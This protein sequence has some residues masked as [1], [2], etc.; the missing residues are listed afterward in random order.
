MLSILKT[1]FPEIIDRVKQLRWYTKIFFALLIIA[2]PIFAKYLVDNFEVIY[3]LITSS[4]HLPYYFI[5]F[6]FLVG[7]LLPIIYKCTLHR[8][9]KSLLKEFV[10]EWKIFIKDFEM[11]VNHVELWF[12]RDGLKQNDDHLW[13][14]VAKYLDKYW[15]RRLRLRELLY[16][17][18]EENLVVHQSKYWVLFKKEEHVFA[19]R[20]YLSPFS[21]LLDLGAPVGTINHYNTAINKSIDVANELVEYLEYKYKY[22]KN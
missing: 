5:F 3:N 16:R 21:F 12:L 19:E 8:S 2:L 20:D 6:A 22:L 13:N 17:I 9:K 10:A 14:N 7:L 18:G 15:D 1:L 4:A 11:L